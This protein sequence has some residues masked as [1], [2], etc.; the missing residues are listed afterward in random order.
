[1][2]IKA[3]FKKRNNFFKGII[4]IIKPN[5]MKPR[6]QR[7]VTEKQEARVGSVLIAKPFWNEENYKRSVIFLLEHDRS[8]SAGIIINK[9][10]TL[11]I[12]DALP[13]LNVL[14]PLYFGGPSEI[15]TVSYIHNNSNVPDAIYIGNELFWGGDYESL[16]EMMNSRK[17]NLKHIK[18]CAGFVHW[19]PGQLE[20]EIFESKWWLDEINPQELFTT[21]PDDLWSYKLISSGHLYGLMNEVPDPVLS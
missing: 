8:G 11:S 1:M 20:E 5:M 2:H 17:I 21:A 12:H 7:R 15:K 10:S 19:A 6:F 13:E 14:Y 4:V 9:P 18:F 3:S 16:V